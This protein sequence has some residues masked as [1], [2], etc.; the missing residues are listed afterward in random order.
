MSEPWM[1]VDETA[2]D[3]GVSNKTVRRH[4]LDLRG[5]RFG[6]RLLFRASAIDK[7]LE[8]QSLSPR[9]RGGDVVAITR[10]RAQ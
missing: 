4:A 9:R 6:S 8:S 2:R 1:G 10:R 5:V 7:F 3:L